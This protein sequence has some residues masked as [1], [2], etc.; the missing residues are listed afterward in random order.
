MLSDDDMPN[1]LFVGDPHGQYA[2]I[3]SVLTDERPEAVIFL[4]DMTLEQPGDDVLGGLAMPSW[5]VHGN[6]DC[7]K[8]HWHDNLFGSALGQNN[9]HGHVVEIGGL[10]LAGLGG[11]FRGKIWH[12]NQPPRYRTRTEYLNT[13][14]PAER[15]RGG[16]PMKQRASIFPED[17]EQLAELRADVLVTH[18]APSTHPHGFE[19]FDQLAAAMGVRWIVHGHHHV[20]YQ[21]VLPDGITVHGVADGSIKRLDGTICYCRPKTSPE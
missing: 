19:V 11:V 13:M 6:H 20:D 7:D 8:P 2:D 10:R 21:T 4:G 15:W 3:L 17:L 18:E 12:P 16:L 9:L 14:R 5:C 1:L